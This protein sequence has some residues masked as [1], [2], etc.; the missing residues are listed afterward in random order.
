M[1]LSVDVSERHGDLLSPVDSYPY[2]ISSCKWLGMI[3]LQKNRGARGS[4]SYDPNPTYCL[5]CLPGDR[6]SSWFGAYATAL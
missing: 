2:V 1:M 6:A 3:S 4:A 5:S